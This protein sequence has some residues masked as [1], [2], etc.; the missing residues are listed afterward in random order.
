MQLFARTQHDTI[1][2]R[3]SL[4]LR[5]VLVATFALASTLLEDGSS[6]LWRLTPPRYADP[7]MQASFELQGGDDRLSEVGTS[8]SKGQ[9][10]IA[11]LSEV[12]IEDADALASAINAVRLLIFEAEP[13][14]IEASVGPVGPELYD[15]TSFILSELLDS[16]M[17]G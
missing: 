14:T 15:L 4:Q 10:M 13:G 3:L 6:D 7:A 1:E 2:L 9:R 16:L 11:K 17:D 12:S 5:E 8:I